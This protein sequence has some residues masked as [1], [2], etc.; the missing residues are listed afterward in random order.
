MES[1]QQ[2]EDL[3]GTE[4]DVSGDESY[5]ETDIRSIHLTTRSISG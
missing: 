5:N 2:L 4:S 1:E 3:E